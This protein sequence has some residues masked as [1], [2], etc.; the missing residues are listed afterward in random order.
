MSLVQSSILVISRWR[1][2]CDRETAFMQA[3]T[4]LTAIARDTQPAAGGNLLLPCQDNPREFVTIARWRSLEDWQNFWQDNLIDA[5]AL[6]T[7]YAT[8]YLLS[9]EVFHTPTPCPAPTDV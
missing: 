4:R 1:V 6:A 3:W 5:S 9:N 7:L 2:R 8:S